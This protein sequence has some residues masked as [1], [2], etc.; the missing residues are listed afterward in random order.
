MSRVSLFPPACLFCGWLYESGNF[1]IF[2]YFFFFPFWIRGEGA[3]SVSWD[4]TAGLKAVL[5]DEV[6]CLFRGGAGLK[7]FG[8]GKGFPHPC[9]ARGAER[10]IWFV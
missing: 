2:F 6:F 5:G 8:K 10:R 7:R 1:F 3:S 4:G 9:V